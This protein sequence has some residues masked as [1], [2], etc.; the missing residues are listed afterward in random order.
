MIMDVLV[1]FKVV[2]DLDQLP[3]GGWEI[4]SALR[5]ETIFVKTMLNPYDESA[6]SWP[7]GRRKCPLPR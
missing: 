2:P 4:D 6:L 7:C 5:V 3:P 1:C